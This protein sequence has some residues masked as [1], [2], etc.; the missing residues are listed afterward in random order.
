MLNYIL[1]VIDEE[2]GEQI[3]QISGFDLVSLEEDFHKVE[4]AVERYKEK[5]VDYVNDTKGDTETLEDEAQ[6]I[7]EEANDEKYD[8]HPHW[9][10][11]Q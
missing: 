2:T 8:Y 10:E 3:A 7:K 4:K 5:G 11:V 1:K 6:R 9:S